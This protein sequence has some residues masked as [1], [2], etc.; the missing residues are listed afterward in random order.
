MLS[1][2]DNKWGRGSYNHQMLKEREVNYRNLINK[3]SKWQIVTNSAPSV[4][5]PPT[6]IIMAC[7]PCESSFR[8]SVR[9]RPSW[10]RPSAL[11]PLPRGQTGWPRLPAS[12]DV[13]DV[14]P[15]LQMPPRRQSYPSQE[16]AERKPVI[17]PAQP[18]PPLHCLSTWCITAPAPS[19]PPQDS[20]KH[21]CV[22]E[23]WWC[24]RLFKHLKNRSAFQRWG[25]GTETFGHW[26]SYHGQRSKVWRYVRRK[27]NEWKTRKMD[28]SSAKLQVYLD[29]DCISFT[30]L[31]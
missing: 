29:Y 9:P 21:A 3:D 11:S 19:R 27:I 22:G 1:R 5:L 6:I 13:N 30:Y 23:D 8:V 16:P 24:N 18:G 7:F 25:G 2:L 4:S 31:D 14:T 28:W 10:A 12:F 17:N 20:P 26:F 15:A